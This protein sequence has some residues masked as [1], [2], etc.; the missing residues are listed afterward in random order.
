MGPL[1]GQLTGLRRRRMWL[2]APDKSYADAIAQ[3]VVGARVSARTVAVGARF[4][5]RMPPESGGRR[6]VALDEALDRVELVAQTIRR[7]FW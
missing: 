5:V 4:A 2:L 3:H 1:R 6:V 7:R